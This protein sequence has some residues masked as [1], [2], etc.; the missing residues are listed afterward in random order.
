MILYLARHGRSLGHGLFLGQSDPALSDDGRRQ[1]LQLAEHLRQSG[2]ERI[3]SSALQRSVQTA[4][5][6]AEATSIVPACDPRLNEVSYGRW[7]GLSW[8]DI[9]SRWPDQARRKLANWWAI[10]PE[11]G[12]PAQAFLER[13]SAAWGD[14]RADTR[15]TLIVGH[16][17]VNGLLAEL[18][19]APGQPDW[20]RVTQFEQGY[21]EVLEIHT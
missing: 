21:G 20:D 15:T 12:E 18:A 6:V 16:A 13:V 5:L 10:T 19:R 8:D 11:G 1:A 3:V 9:E 17:G 2:I 4:A 7:D 14:L